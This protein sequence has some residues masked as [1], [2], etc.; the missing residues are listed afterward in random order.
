MARLDR[1][2]PIKEIAQIGA[3]IGR[4]FPF[5]LLE[6]VS[7]VRGVALQEALEQL[8]AAG[9]IFG[10]KAPSEM[11][12]AFKHA[13]VQETAYATLLKSRKQ[14]LHQRIAQSLRDRFPERAERE[15][16]IVAHHFTQAG[17]PETAI[18]WWGR[19]G[20]RAMHRFANHEAALSYVNGLDLMTDLPA[21]EERDRQELAYRLA[22]GPALLAARGYASDEV[23][24]NYQEA[25]R[26]AEALSDRE[27]AFTSARGQWHYLYDRSELDRALALA[28]RL[29]AIGAQESGTEKSSLAFRA[30]G[31]TLMS[32]GEFV[33]A[34]EAFERV[35]A[36]GSDTPPGACF[37][38]H[39]EEPHIVA[40]QY[41][42]L[43]LAVRGYTDS[44]LAS[45][46]SALS[47][48]MTLNFPLMVAF[49]S[50]AVGMVLMLRRD[51]RACAA[52]VREQIEFCSEQGFIFWS[53]AHEIL[54]GASRTCLDRDRDGI[55]QVEDG[56]KSWKRTGAALHIP[57]WSSYLAEAALCVGDIDRAE[58]AVVNGIKTSERHGDAFALADLKRLAGCVL[59]RQGC[60]D[61]ARRAFEA[62]VDMAQQQ[63][64][65]LY[66]LRAGRDLARLIADRGDVAGA[67]EILSP[68][69]EMVPE[70][71]TGLD[72]QEV[73]ELLSTLP[74]VRAEADPGSIH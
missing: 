73:S 51:Y 64:A 9:L 14:Q 48:A 33:R 35:I 27:A 19:A 22:L 53:A 15:P 10:H 55:A 2:A 6:T 5:G 45:A 39:G 38:K 61:R 62:S 25:G 16:G 13:L 40:L 7:P 66:L 21:S 23:E 32:K 42:G 29:G 4:E 3:A 44:G 26:L 63:H 70:H 37:A 18:E 43:S 71:R 56:I 8:M 20:S 41:K 12:Y 74:S 72:Y 17:L 60:H 68:I 1:L 47:L 46:Q 28:E 59:L 24:R 31:S 50:T 54:H 34:T 52:L 49:A 11:T 58:K 30:V 57:T 65:G 69:A 67:W 36:Y